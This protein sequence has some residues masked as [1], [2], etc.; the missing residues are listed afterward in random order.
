MIQQLLLLKLMQQRARRTGMTW[1]YIK[2][3]P[4]VGINP[5]A[6][7]VIYESKAKTDARGGLGGPDTAREGS[8]EYKHPQE[9]T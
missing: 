1:G 5:D 4:I 2:K 3:K 9:E 7:G 6:M 8:T